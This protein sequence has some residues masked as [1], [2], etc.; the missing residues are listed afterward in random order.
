MRLVDGRLQRVYKTLWQSLRVFWLAAVAQHAD[1]TYVVCG[2]QRLTYMDVHREALK[3]ANVFQS[4]YR[5]G[6]GTSV[7][8]CGLES[9]RD[10]CADLAMDY[11][12]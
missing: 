12:R 7:R 4:V 11:R 9:V 5:I 8:C 6:K 10:P 1:K 3:A 2:D